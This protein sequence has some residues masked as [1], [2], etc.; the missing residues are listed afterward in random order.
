[1]IQMI[2]MLLMT[3][4]CLAGFISSLRKKLIFPAVYSFI[5]F[6]VLGWATYMGFAHLANL[7]HI[8]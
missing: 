1:M 8:G 6:A 4:F 7:P 5:A 3:I 2:I